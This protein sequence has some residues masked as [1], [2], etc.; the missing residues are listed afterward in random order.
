MRKLLQAIFRTKHE[1]EFGRWLKQPIPL[2]P[3]SVPKAK[4]GYILVA[5]GPGDYEI[6]DGN[7][8]AGSAYRQDGDG[9]NQSIWSTAVRGA[10]WDFPTLK[11]ARA[12]LGDP[13]IRGRRG[14]RAS[15]A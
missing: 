3:P 1:R 10:S 6:L 8:L 9:N 4:H 15:Q 14:T 13:P 11:A 7:H 5:V 2:E 12:W